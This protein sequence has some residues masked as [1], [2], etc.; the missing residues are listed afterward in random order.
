MNTNKHQSL[1]SV[2][3]H[4][5]G[6]VLMVGLCNVRGLCSMQSLQTHDI[7]ADIDGECHETVVLDKVPT[8]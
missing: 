6:N 5:Y 3:S 8:A 1:T 4:K 2:V 7:I